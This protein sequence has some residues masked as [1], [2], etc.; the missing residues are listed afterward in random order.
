MQPQSGDALQK[1]ATQTGSF[2]SFLGR[3]KEETLEDILIFQVF[4]KMLFAP[5]LCP[6]RRC[7]TV[8]QDSA[9]VD[10]AP[11][12]WLWTVSSARPFGCGKLSAD[13]RRQQKRGRR[14]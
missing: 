6:A 2:G 9:T 13:E 10:R 5:L 8:I 11:I 12:F 7:R 3:S 4:S 14:I 1:K